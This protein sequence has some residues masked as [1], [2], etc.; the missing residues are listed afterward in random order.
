M[1]RADRVLDMSTPNTI[2]MWVQVKRGVIEDGDSRYRIT[3]R[4]GRHYLHDL[5]SNKVYG[6]ATKAQARKHAERLAQ[7]S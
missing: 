4:R 3:T 6:F 5:T 1:F 2:R 7:V